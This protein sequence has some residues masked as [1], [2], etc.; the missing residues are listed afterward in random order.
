M[1]QRKCQLY[2]RLSNTIHTATLVMV[3]AVIVL[4]Q[5][6][7]LLPKCSQGIDDFP[8]FSLRCLVR[9]FDGLI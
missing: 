1:S 3:L 6:S 8:S 9:A 4:E 2:T 5:D 7:S